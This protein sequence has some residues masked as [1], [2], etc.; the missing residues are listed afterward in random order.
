[1]KGEVISMAARIH[2]V[3]PQEVVLS[4]RDLT[5]S[6]PIGM[7]RANA[8]EDI[9]FE[10]NEAFSGRTL[11]A[12]SVT[13][14][15]HYRAPFMPLIEPVAFVSP[16]D[17]AILGPL[18]KAVEDAAVL[19]VADLVVPP[20]DPDAH[21]EVGEQARRRAKPLLFVALLQADHV[22]NGNRP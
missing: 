6:L 2:A 13:H 8:V 17:P 7:E 12:L 9:S 16:D 4:V 18:R 3:V 21:C 11:G 14:D 15:E 1:L 20:E 22:R 10:G 5:V 19:A